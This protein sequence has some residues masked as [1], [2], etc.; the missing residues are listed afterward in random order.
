MTFPRVRFMTR[1]GHD[2]SDRFAPLVQAARALPVRDAVFDGEVCVVDP[3]GRTSF[4]ALQRSLSSHGGDPL[5][6]FAL[7]GSISKRAEGPYR[8]GRT[9]D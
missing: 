1:G 2:W 3:E 6:Y 4:S 7:E 8:S 9:R 5:V